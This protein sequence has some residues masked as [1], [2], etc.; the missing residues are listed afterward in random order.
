MP[1]EDSFAS[2]G[3]G[4]AAPATRSFVI[5]PHA[6][7]DLVRVTRALYVGS[8]G[9]LTVRFKGDTTDRTLTGL[10]TGAVYPFRLSAVRAAGATAGSLV[11]LD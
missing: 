2:S 10:Q 1:A 11:G 7:D 5:T 3:G 9:N 4:I 8:G 6:T